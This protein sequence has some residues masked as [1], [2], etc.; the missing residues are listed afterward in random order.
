MRRNVKTEFRDLYK[1]NLT[2][3][4]KPGRI[5]PQL[6]TNMALHHIYDLNKHKTIESYTRLPVSEE[7]LVGRRSEVHRSGFRR[8]TRY[9]ASEY[10]QNLHV[11]L[12]HV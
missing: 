11:G 7:H 9:G 2:V 3:P 10:N 12:E 5:L 6:V 8:I 4:G 1:G